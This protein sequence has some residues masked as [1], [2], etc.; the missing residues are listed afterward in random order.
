MVDNNRIVGASNPGEWQ[1]VGSTEKSKRRG[2]AI[3]GH[4][5]QGKSHPSQ[6]ST[7]R[8]PRTGAR[9]MGLHLK[10][11]KG[12][13][14]DLPGRDPVQTYVA[15]SSDVI[16]G[17]GDDGSHSPIRDQ[18]AFF[19]M[20]RINSVPEATQPSTNTAIKGAMASL[21]RNMLN[22]KECEEMHPEL[23]HI[24]KEIEDTQTGNTQALKTLC[25][26][27][28]I[29][30]D[31]YIDRLPRKNGRPILPSQEWSLQLGH[32]MGFANYYNI[33]L[34]NLQERMDKRGLSGFAP[35]LATGVMRMFRIMAATISTALGGE[36]KNLSAGI[37]RI[38]WY[39]PE[40]PQ[41]FHYIKES[42]VAISG[43]EVAD[44][45]LGKAVGQLKAENHPSLHFQNIRVVPSLKQKERSLSAFFVPQVNHAGEIFNVDKSDDAEF[46]NLED[47]DNFLLGIVEQEKVKPHAIEGIFYLGSQYPFCASCAKA[48]KEFQERWPGI[49][50]IPVQTHMVIAQQD[51]PEL[52]KAGMNPSDNA[53]NIGH[54]ENVIGLHHRHLASLE[55]KENESKEGIARESVPSVASFPPLSGNTEADPGTRYSKGGS[56]AKIA[57]STPPV[58]NKAK[59]EAIVSES[60]RS[61]PLSS[62]LPGEASKPQKARQPEKTL[63]V[64]D[65]WE[66]GVS[67]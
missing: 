64:L 14:I 27:V 46:K 7:A 66:E 9:V 39:S 53:V 55:Q 44:R 24:W 13:W 33:A 60:G 16:Y 8:T 5:P 2:R 63:V 48:I 56:W 18:A 38:G 37:C 45:L 15:P 6:S 50:V 49:L 62:A 34:P 4:P 26:K 17:K 19:K 51:K 32:I 10:Q 28:A 41:E 54:F 67:D 57:S 21:V 23:E 42:F 3:S 52:E 59:S 1:T 61:D 36:N 25:D 20:F 11:S 30:A 58:K 31:T 40:N 12:K 43:L 22:T 29:K 35:E 65:S 47:L